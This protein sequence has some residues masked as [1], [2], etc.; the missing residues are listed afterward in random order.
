MSDRVFRQSSLNGLFS[1]WPLLAKCF[2]DKVFRQ[3]VQTVC[4]DRGQNHVSKLG[5]QTG[6]SDRVFRQG[7]QTGCSD[8]AIWGQTGCSDKAI[9]LC[10]PR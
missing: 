6:Y 7:V 8:R 5:V 1:K 10:F 2:S 4:S 9:W 3:G